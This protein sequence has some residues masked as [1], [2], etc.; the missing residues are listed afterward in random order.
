MLKDLFDEKS[1]IVN[2]HAATKEGAIR[3]LLECVCKKHPSVKK[4]EA[5]A[6]LLS[7]EKSMS[8][9]IMHGIA[10]PHANCSSLDTTAIAIGI[11]ERGIQYGSLDGDAVHFVMLILF[12]EGFTEAHLKIMKE[13]AELVMQHDFLKTVLAKKNAHEVYEIL[14][15]FEKMENDNG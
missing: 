4:D 3:E 9:G 14:S 1:I 11:S 5:L 10:I 6:A 2:L 15:S 12:E 8:T 13:A 7:R